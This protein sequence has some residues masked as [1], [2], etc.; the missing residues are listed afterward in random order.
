MVDSIS[1]PEL[2]TLD[3]KP[4]TELTGDWRNGGK[5]DEEPAKPKPKDNK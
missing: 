3:Y 2:E 4:N 1:K 5:I